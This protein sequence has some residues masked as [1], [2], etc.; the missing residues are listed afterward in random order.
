M[1]TD[2]KKGYGLISIA[3]HWIVAAAIIFLFT[4]GQIFEEL[5]RSDAGRTLRM[6]HVSIGA[7]AAAF[8]IA[9]FVWRLAQGAPDKGDE[10]VPLYLL[11]KAIQWALLL[12]PLGLVISGF[13]A[14]WS[15]GRDVSLF[16]L[17]AIP[18]PIAESADLHETMEEVHEFFANLMLPLVALHVLGGL[19]HL[20]INRDGVMKRIFV[21]AR[22]D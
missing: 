15:G 5:G 13:L 2:T 10:P 17:L 16:G 1:L 19:K 20:I 14:V 22:A 3:L 12:A 9:R 18:A 11:A 8:F 7:I 4:S 6:V 21:P